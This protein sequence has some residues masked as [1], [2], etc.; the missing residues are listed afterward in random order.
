MP[1]P[2]LSANEMPLVAF[3]GQL[4][5]EPGFDVLTLAAAE[6]IGLTHRVIRHGPVRSLAEAARARGVA[7]AILQALNASMADISDPEAAA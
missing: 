3:D 6:S 7:P 2:L 1:T 4:E 5:H